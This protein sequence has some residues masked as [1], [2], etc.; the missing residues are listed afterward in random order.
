M[1]SE[2]PI[3][4]TEYHLTAPAKAE[5][6]VAHRARTIDLCDVLAP[7]SVRLE[8]ETIWQ[9]V[10]ISIPALVDPFTVVASPDLTDQA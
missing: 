5:V 1:A 4:I 7:A 6:V 2:P 3:R 9:T 10:C 8:D